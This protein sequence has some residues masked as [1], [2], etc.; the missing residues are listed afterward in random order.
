MENNSQVLHWFLSGNRRPGFWG[1]TVTMG[2]IIDVSPQLIQA[3]GYCVM[4]SQFKAA[5]EP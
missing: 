1:F 5:V 4:N 3:L 2:K